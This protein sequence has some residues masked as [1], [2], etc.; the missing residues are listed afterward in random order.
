MCGDVCTIII[1]FLHLSVCE[2]VSDVRVGGH[3]KLIDPSE[4]YF[5]LG[6]A[7]LGCYI[8][9][10]IDIANNGTSHD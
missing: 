7:G 8:R 1:L 9:Q 6:I 2:G 3:K 5:F 10:P 4:K